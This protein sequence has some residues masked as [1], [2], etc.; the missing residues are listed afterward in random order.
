MSCMLFTQ[1]H[2]A[3]PA[4]LHIGNCI[5]KEQLLKIPSHLF[6]SSTVSA[7]SAAS[8]LRLSNCCSP[9][10]GPWLLPV[11]RRDSS[12]S[13]ERR[14]QDEEQGTSAATDTERQPYC[15]L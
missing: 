13:S 6:L 1:L 3:N 11:L 14:L 7:A 8:R 15:L 12:S 4:L 10:L 9:A 5:R 2:H